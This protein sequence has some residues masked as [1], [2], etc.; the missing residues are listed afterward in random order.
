VSRRLR[1]AVAFGISAFILARASEPEGPDKADVATERRVLRKGS[2][3]SGSWGMKTEQLVQMRP[4][5]VR[6]ARKC[7]SLTHPESMT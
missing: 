5:I 1:I 6:I 2:L 7:F 3:E 4:K